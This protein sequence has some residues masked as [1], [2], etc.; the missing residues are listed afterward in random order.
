[1][2]QTKCCPKEKK[3]HILLHFPQAILL[4]LGRPSA[5]GLS[6]SKSFDFSEP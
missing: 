4:T 2:L 6:L 3:H 5:S 1:M